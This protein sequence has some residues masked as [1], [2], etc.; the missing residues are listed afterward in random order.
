MFDKHTV[1]MGYIYNRETATVLHCNKLFIVLKGT[2][3]FCL[4]SRHDSLSARLDDKMNEI[5]I[6][7]TCNYNI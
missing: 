4:P 2:A 7:V 6:L 5:N 3:H 1:F